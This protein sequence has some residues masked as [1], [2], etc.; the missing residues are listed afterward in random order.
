MIRSAL[1]CMPLCV[2]LV[3]LAWGQEEGPQR[4]LGLTQQAPPAAGEV[5]EPDERSAD[6][7]TLD[8]AIA[9]A[10]RQNRLVKNAALE[11]EKAGDQ[12][13]ATKTLRLPQFDVSVTPAYTVT[14]LD[15]TFQRGVFGTFAATGP[16]PPAETTL[17]TDPQYSTAARATVSQPVSQLYKLGLAIDQ[18][19]VSRDVSRQDLR[20]QRQSTVSRVKRAYYAVL[21]AQSGLEALREQVGASR[22]LVRVVADQVGQQAALRADLL[23]ARA[24]LAQA[25][26]AVTAA[27]HDLASRREQLN[28]LLGRSPDTPLRVSAV[29]PA[30]PSQMDVDL[31]RE[32]ALRQR[33]EIARAGLEV[34]HADYGVRLKKAEFIPDV[35]LVF[36][37]LA[38][39]TSD[40]LPRNIAYVGVQINWD[41]WD[42][43]RKNDD[44]AL[45]RRTLDQAKNAVAEATSRVI[46]DVNAAFRRLEDS[47]AYLAVAELNRDAAREKFRVITHQYREQAA[48]LQDVLVAQAA[49]GQTSDQY[50]QAVL[51][52]WEARAEFE[53]ALGGE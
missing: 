45:R 16:I 12:I 44:L 22:E 19:E 40:V 38:P 33:P 41:V 17:H 23:Q 21:Q 36:Q 37:Y 47:Q 29:P 39:I 3:P 50:R 43:G 18:L 14:P 49:L 7:L 32:V 1:L 34:S 13:A 35:S 48:L 27:R 8:E 52:V 5:S 11:V 25:E 28:H 15:V 9:L 26:Y 2:L 6:A 4:P 10:L 53:R 31:A 20:A 30:I 42:W 51:S 46:L 24:G